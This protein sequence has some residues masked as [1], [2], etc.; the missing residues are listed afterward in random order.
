MLNVP[1]FGRRETAVFALE[2][3]KDSIHSSQ[4]AEPYIPAPSPFR[5]ESLPLITFMVVRIIQFTSIFLHLHR[6]IKIPCKRPTSVLLAIRKDPT[7]DQKYST[8]LSALRTKVQIRE[9][10]DLPTAYDFIRR[11]EENSHVDVAGIFT[12]D[13]WI[14]RADGGGRGGW[15][16]DGRVRRGEGV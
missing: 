3:T 2:R 13:D 8:V 4:G 5:P 9:I 6:D 11:L 10:Q 12:T 1:L 15:R 7:F 16:W 14:F